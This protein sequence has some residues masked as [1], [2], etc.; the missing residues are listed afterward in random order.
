MSLPSLPQPQPW[1]PACVGFVPSALSQGRDSL[2]SCEA[3]ALLVAG[4]D[5]PQLWRPG[6]QG[7]GGM[8]SGRA[9]RLVPCWHLPARSAG[10]GGEGLSGA[11]LRTLISFP[12]SPPHDVITSQYQNRGVRISTYTFRRDSNVQTQAVEPIEFD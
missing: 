1:I 10:G 9:L 12:G 5:F 4:P 6:A 2:R 3:G 11:S 8:G 7:T